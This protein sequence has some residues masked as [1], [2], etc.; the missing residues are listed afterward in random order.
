MKTIPKATIIVTET[1]KQCA[2]DK[3]GLPM[4]ERSSPCRVPSVEQEEGLRR[5]GMLASTIPQCQALGH[6]RRAQMKP[7]PLTRI[8]PSFA[9]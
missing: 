6:G 7:I 1:R 4:E 5:E 8:L 2:L 9:P 3:K